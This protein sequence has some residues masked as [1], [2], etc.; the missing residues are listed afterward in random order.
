MSRTFVDEGATK[1]MSTEAPT[2]TISDFEATLTK[3][4]SAVASFAK[5]D[6]SLIYVLRGV[7][8][9]YPTLI[10]ALVLLISV[11]VVAGAICGFAAW[12]AIGRVGSAS[13]IA[14]DTVP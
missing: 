4:D 2:K 7:L 8:R 12:I 14:F 1:A 11:Y 13:P 5:D 10:P 9:V 3:A 6:K